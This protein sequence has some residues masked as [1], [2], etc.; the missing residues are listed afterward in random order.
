MITIKKNYFKVADNDKMKLTY[1][2]LSCSPRLD[3]HSIVNLNETTGK[4]KLKKLNENELDHKFSLT[5]QVSLNA[6]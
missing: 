4:I 3:C 6:L 2:M 1:K 5:V